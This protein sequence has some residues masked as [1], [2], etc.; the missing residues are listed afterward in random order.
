MGGGGK[1]G[2]GREVTQKLCDDHVM[3]CD[4]HIYSRVWCRHEHPH[5]LQLSKVSRHVGA[6]DHVDDE[7]SHCTKL[8]LLQILQN[9][10]VVLRRVG[11][12]EK[13]KEECKNCT[14]V[15]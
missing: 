6:E 9:I 14:S 7:G 8:F 15:N 11:R 5:L 10:Q 3:S 2:R 12:R 4:V 1:G 13:N